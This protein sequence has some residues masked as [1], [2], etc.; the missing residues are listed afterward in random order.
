M[1]TLPFAIQT[2]ES[3]YLEFRSDV[4]LDKWKLEYGLFT[5]GKLGQF[6]QPS[7]F[8]VKYMYQVRKVIDDVYIF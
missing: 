4:F 6:R 3:C 7:H 1:C 5:E 2:V 8:L